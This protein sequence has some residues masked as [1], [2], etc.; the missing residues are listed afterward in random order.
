MITHRFEYKFQRFRLVF[1]GTSGDHSSALPH[2]KSYPVDGGSQ[3]TM[4]NV[5]VHQRSSRSCSTMHSKSRQVVHLPFYCSFPQL[6]FFM[7]R[8]FLF[9]S[10]L[11]FS[12]SPKDHQREKR[13]RKTI[14]GSTVEPI[15]KNTSLS[16]RY[17]SGARLMSSGGVLPE[18]I[19]LRALKERSRFNQSNRHD[20]FTRSLLSS[21]AMARRTTDSPQ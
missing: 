6:S 14:D 16:T 13:I 5:V 4:I 2:Q 21:M 10:A 7:S 18:P 20:A 15:E 11:F 3:C 19:D 1:L 17:T 12:R 8:L 9:V